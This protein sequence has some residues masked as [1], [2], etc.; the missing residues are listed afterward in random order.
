MID[1][2]LVTID[3]IV[4]KFTDGK[5]IFE[6][7]KDAKKRYRNGESIYSISQDFK[8]DFRIIRGWIEQTNL[9]HVVK[10]LRSL[11][12]N[13]Q[14]PLYVTYENFCTINQLVSWVLFSGNIDNKYIPK[15]GGTKIQFEDISLKLKKE[16]NIETVLNNND[17]RINDANLG[18]LLTALG[19]HNGK[20]KRD[21]ELTLPHYIIKAAYLIESDL[22]YATIV[23]DFFKTAFEH[24]IYVYASNMNLITPRQ[25]TYFLADKF[26]NEI[27]TCLNKLVS[28]FEFT[29]RVVKHNPPK[30]SSPNHIPQYGYNANI[31]I[32]VKQRYLLH[33]KYQLPTL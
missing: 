22:S 31:P 18:R 27:I 16:F 26:G 21:S 13:I 30:K 3:D 29:Y 28:E 24:R 15:I 10:G 33:N 11:R 12:K 20:S 23:K 8:R 6:Q 25:K 17:L 14:I 9:P 5:K 4:N 7:Y 32:L 2:Q 19:V 1:E